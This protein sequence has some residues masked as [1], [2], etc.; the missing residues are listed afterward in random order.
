MREPCGS[1][2]E[3]GLMSLKAKA[4]LH[5]VDRIKV[6]PKGS[7]QEGRPQRLW[8]RGLAP[9]F[10]AAR[11]VGGAIRAFAAAGELPLPPCPPR[12]RHHHLRCCCLR[13]RRP[14]ACC[15]GCCFA[16]AFLACARFS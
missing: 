4:S 11:R 16:S 1:R 15:R 3:N 14:L 13:R 7:G 8:H 2:M 12:L 5:V 9:N 10:L 6:P